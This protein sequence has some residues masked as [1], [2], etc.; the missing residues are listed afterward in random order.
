MLIAPKN[1]WQGNLNLIVRIPHG[2]EDAP[3]G[4]VWVTLLPA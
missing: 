2:R 3:E 4:G 1:T